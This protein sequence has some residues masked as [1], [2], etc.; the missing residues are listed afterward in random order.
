MFIT[1]LITANHNL[2]VFGGAGG[3]HACDIARTLKISRIIIHK[4][5]SIL[6]A[7]GKRTFLV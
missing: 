6:S 5:S 2:G 7:Y 1:Y 4:F 3:Q